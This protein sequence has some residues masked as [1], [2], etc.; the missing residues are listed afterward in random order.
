VTV[1][2]V[3]LEELISEDHFCR[4]IDASPLALLVR[5]KQEIK[6]LSLDLWQ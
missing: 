5:K 1:F 2:R 6:I 4:V 3:T